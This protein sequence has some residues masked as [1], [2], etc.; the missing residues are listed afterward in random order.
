[1]RTKLVL[2]FEKLKF[3]LKKVKVDPIYF[4][5]PAVLSILSAIFEG[6]SVS[7]VIPLLKG[8]FTMN[9]VFVKDLPAF[10]FFAG[11]FPAFSHLNN[12]MI[13]TILLGV[14]FTTGLLKNILRYFS[15]LMICLQIRNVAHNLR[16]IIFS[17]YLSF[18]KMF[19][20][21]SNIGYLYNVLV[22]FTALITQELSNIH[23]FLSE[24]FTFLVYITIMFAISWKLSLLVLV[25]FPV[26][27]YSVKML[28]EKIK[29][30]SLSYSNH[31]G[32]FS[33]QISNILSCIPLVK[34]YANEDHERTKFSIIST[35]IKNMEFS[36][37]KK[38]QL[39]SPLQETI[40]L[41]IILLAAC[42]M[43]FIVVKRKATDV[44]SLLV[45]FYLLRMSYRSFGFFNSVKGSFA[46]VNGPISD[47]ANVLN[48]Q[49]KFFIPS[50]K[51]KF[52]GLKGRI[53]FKNL[54]FSYTQ[55]R[56]VLKD[57]NFDIEK[58]KITA[59]VGPT[60]AGKTTLVN[61]L[62]RLYDSPPGSILIDG[63]DIRDFDLSSLLAHFAYVSQDITLF[64]D[65][66]KNNIIYGLRDRF[67]EEKLIAAVKISRLDNFIN[68]LPQGFN[69]H[70]GDKGVKLS[71]GEK[72][73][74]SI[75]R[76]FLKGANI[77]ILDEATSSLDNQTERLIQEAIDEAVKDKTTI[78]IA[79]RLSTIKN[80]DKIVVIEDGRFIEGGI[81]TELLEKRGK[82]FEYWESQKFY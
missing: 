62:L 26:F 78:V 33:K 67:T 7:T 38:S 58:N 8:V 16:Q 15:S 3:F 61:L 45:Y 24:F 37:D 6:I 1:M 17:R 71:G 19:F 50:G 41:M 40:V 76:A 32:L 29:K 80:A 65:T 59:I 44:A 68:S 5:L 39:I 11:I 21:R 2:N 10:K 43:G 47:I 25:T 22:N 75:A 49:D 54:T 13:F 51:R 64:N 69:T 55:D 52:S 79:H 60:G 35:E 72:Q 53:E 82:F 81:L 4:I 77:L 20:D 74:V 12:T 27:T 9:F 48:D 23:S 36:L 42:L 63:D 66:I 34:L 28:I 18:G 73:R 56:Q 46:R 70:I 14:I 30:T 31:Y 57:V